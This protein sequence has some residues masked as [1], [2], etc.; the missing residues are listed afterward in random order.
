MP[1]SLRNIIV[2]TAL[3]AVFVTEGTKFDYMAPE[4]P[5]RL[6]D[7]FCSVKCSILQ[8]RGDVQCQFCVCEDSQNYVKWDTTPDPRQPT[9]YTTLP[10][11]TIHVNNIWYHKVSDPCDMVS[12]RVCPMKCTERPSIKPDGTTCTVCDCQGAAVLI[13]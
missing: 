10:P 3:V 7:R 4:N 1:M 9:V 12:D 13:G 6:E 5:C 8:L 11:D 2:C